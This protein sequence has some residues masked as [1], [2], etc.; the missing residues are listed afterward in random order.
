VQVGS[1]DHRIDTVKK[2]RNVGSGTL[3]LKPKGQ[4]G[5]FKIMGKDEKG[6]TIKGTV[7]CTTFSSPP[8][9]AG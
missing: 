3:T 1:A 7:E 9:E 8:A 6:A 2:S 5:T 4:G